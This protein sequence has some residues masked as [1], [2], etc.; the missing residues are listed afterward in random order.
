MGC[1][2]G[3]PEVPIIAGLC[4]FASTDENIFAG[5]CSTGRTGRWVERGLDLS[6]VPVLGDLT[7]QPNVWVALQLKREP[8]A[9]FSEG[10]FVDNIAVHKCIEEGCGANTLSMT[11]IPGSQMRE[12]AT[13]ETL[14]R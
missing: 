9:S 4:G 13:N 10:V 8:S 2:G 14:E 5:W 7:G 3:Q 12:V 1:W 11:S 6:D